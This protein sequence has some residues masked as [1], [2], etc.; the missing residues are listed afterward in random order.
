MGSRVFYLDQ[1]ISARH[2]HIG[3]KGA[4]A[5]CGHVPPYPSRVAKMAQLLLCMQSVA[6]GNGRYS[7]PY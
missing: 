6:R 5:R 3:G 2:L 7:E 4:G 1:S